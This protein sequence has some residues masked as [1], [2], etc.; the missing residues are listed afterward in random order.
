MAIKEVYPL[1]WPDSWIRTRPQDRTLMRQWKKSANFYR[2]GLEKEM[3]RMR[4]V[5][6]LISTNV[7]ENARGAL[8]GPEP[9]DPG[10]SV[11]WSVK[12][13]ED[14]AWQDVLDIH[15]PVTTE[16]RIKDA[17][18]ARARIHHPDR[19]G[20]AQMFLALTKARDNALRYINRAT[21]QNFSLVI[22]C[23]AFKTVANNLAAIVGTI[24]AIRKIE[25]CGTSALLERAFKGFAALPQEAS[26]VH[27]T[28]PAR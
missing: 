10:V 21:D 18:Q 8:S 3:T 4:A 12:G 15:E 23:D 27:V 26:H 20:D 25:R 24:Q 22:A 19:G 9:L 11:W 16:E 5:S 7:P 17:F 1:F 14:F 2:D 28:T 6:F 13:E